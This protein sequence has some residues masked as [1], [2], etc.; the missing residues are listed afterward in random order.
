MDGGAPKFDPVIKSEVQ[1]K[2]IEAS[3]KSNDDSLDMGA[4][5]KNVVEKEGGQPSTINQSSIDASEVKSVALKT[6]LST[7][8]RPEA[9]KFDIKVMDEKNFKN[10]TIDVD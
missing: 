1:I 5:S 9:K 3:E 10:K 6:V 7:E 8:E 2:V 4:E